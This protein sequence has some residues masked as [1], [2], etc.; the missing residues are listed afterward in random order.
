MFKP[1]ASIDHRLGRVFDQT[2]NF[3]R[4]RVAHSRADRPDIDR[5]IHQLL[6][7]FD[8]L[9]HRLWRRARGD[10]R[11]D[12]FQDVNAQETSARSH[13]RHRA[14]HRRAGQAARSCDDADATEFVLVSAERATRHEVTKRRARSRRLVRSPGRRSDICERRHFDPADMLERFVRNQPAL[15]EA[16]RD[17]EIGHDAIGI[18]LACIRV[19]A[20]RQIGGENEGVLFTFAVG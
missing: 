11:V 2:K 6:V 4:A 20:G 5:L 16:D 13:R 7:G 12:I 17:D 14:E 15:C 10:D 3:A 1:S 19:E 9:D 8:R 18:G